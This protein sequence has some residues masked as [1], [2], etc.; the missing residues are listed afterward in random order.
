MKP[1]RVPSS[2][3]WEPD[4]DEVRE[5]AL[6]HTAERLRA[7]HEGMDRPDSAKESDETLTPQQI[8]ICAE[9][10]V[11]PETFL[12]VKRYMRGPVR[13]GGQ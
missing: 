12:A 7:W 11:S 5:L 13:E 6:R 4:P 1:P 10:G 2:A 9:K 8:A 3:D